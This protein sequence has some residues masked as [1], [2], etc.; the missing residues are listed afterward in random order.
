MTKVNG[1]RFLR[2]RTCSIFL[3]DS[4]LVLCSIPLLAQEGWR[5]HN[6]I[7]FRSIMSQQYPLSSDPLLLKQVHAMLEQESTTY[8]VSRDYFRRVGDAGDWDAEVEVSPS[9]RAMMLSWGYQI[10]ESC[11]LKRNVAIYAMGYM[12]RFLSNSCSPSAQTVLSNQYDF[13]LCFI[14]CILIAMKNYSGLSVELDFASKI[15]CNGIYSVQELSAMEM[16][17]LQGLEWRLN[18]PS[19]IDF[20]HAFVQMLPPQE[21]TVLDA[22][23]RVSEALVEAAIMDYSLMLQSSPSSMAYASILAASECL[24][25]SYSNPLEWATW[26]QCIAR[27]TGLPEDNFTVQATKGTLISSFMN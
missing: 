26:K 2:W 5:S 18:G 15:V 3:D 1:R 22:M 9:T 10:A 24:N 13:Q 20:V 8:R 12:D 27:I 6:Q 19:P 21:K 17:V 4:Q 23:I 11:K 7:I 14:T 16:H 25:F